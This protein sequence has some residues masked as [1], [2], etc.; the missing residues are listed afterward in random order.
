MASDQ[1]DGFLRLHPR[2]VDARVLLPHRSNLAPAYVV[3]VWFAAHCSSKALHPCRRGSAASQNQAAS[4]C[5][6]KM[7]LRIKS[8]AVA[9]PSIEQLCTKFAARLKEAKPDALLWLTDSFNKRQQPQRRSRVAP[10]ASIGARTDAGLIGG[11]SAANTTARRATRR[12]SRRWPSRTPAPRTPFDGHSTARPKGCRSS[13]TGLRWQA[14][15]PEEAPPLYL[16]AAP[17]ANAGLILKAGSR[18]W[19]R[20]CH[21]RRRSA[22]S[23]VRIASS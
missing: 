3:H 12:V 21:G 5:Q 18:A 6:H 23:S 4:P 20:P 13:T 11:G 9:A 17:P 7:A 8:L 10:A 19:T 2:R 1:L 16:L 15:P 14:A 22:A